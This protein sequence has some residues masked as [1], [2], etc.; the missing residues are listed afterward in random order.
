MDICCCFGPDLFVEPGVNERIRS[1]HLP[2]GKFPDLWISYNLQLSESYPM[3][4][5]QD[6][7]QDD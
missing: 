5:P 1:Y 3:Y 6:S 2:H 7:K 4:L